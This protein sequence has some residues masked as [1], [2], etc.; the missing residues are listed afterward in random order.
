MKSVCRTAQDCLGKD[1]G[2]GIQFTA[3]AKLIYD[4]AKQEGVGRDLPL[5]WFEQDVNSWKRGSIWHEQGIQSTAPTSSST[6]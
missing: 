5:E 6:S 3:M 4:L 1:L 2:Y